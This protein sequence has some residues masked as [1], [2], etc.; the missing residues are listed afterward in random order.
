MNSKP[1]RQQFKNKI[2]EYFGVDK[3]VA[4]NLTMIW[5]MMQ[6]E[7]VWDVEQYMAMIDADELDRDSIMGIFDLEYNAFTDKY[8]VVMPRESGEKDKIFAIIKRGKE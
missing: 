1:T 2:S 5:D 3:K 6:R 7:H 4:E 8:K